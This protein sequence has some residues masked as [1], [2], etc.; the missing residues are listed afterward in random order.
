MNDKEIYLATKARLCLILRN[1]NP[2][3]FEMI[4]ELSKE[5]DNYRDKIKEMENRINELILKCDALT[6]KEPAVTFTTEH[7]SDG[8]T[9]TVTRNTANWKL[10][11]ECLLI[12]GY[13]VCCHFDDDAE[14]ITIEYFRA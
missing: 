13:F 9:M 6:Q 2:T 1:D 5:N 3:P 10:V 12:N 4:V 8:G 11:T 14:T 7:T